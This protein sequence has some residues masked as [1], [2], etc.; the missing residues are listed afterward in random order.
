MTEQDEPQENVFQELEFESFNELNTFLGKIYYR[1]YYRGVSNYGYSLKSKLQRVLEDNNSDKNLWYFKEIHSILYFKR[2]Y[3]SIFA[4]YPDDKDLISW[5]SL[6]QHYGAPT[7]L[8]DW[9][10][11]PYVALYFAYNTNSPV[12]KK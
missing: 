4:Q 5:L 6:M 7:R 2:N 12:T 8:L 11:S 1:L 10:L 9:S 3:K